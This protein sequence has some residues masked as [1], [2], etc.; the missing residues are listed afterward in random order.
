MPKDHFLSFLSFCF[1]PFQICR[2]FPYASIVLGASGNLYSPKEVQQVPTTL[3]RQDTLGC[4]SPIAGFVNGACQQLPNDIDIDAIDWPVHSL[5]SNLGTV[6]HH[7]SCHSL[8]PSNTTD[9]DPEWRSVWS[10]GVISDVV[11]VKNTS[12]HL[13]FGAHPD[14]EESTHKTPEGCALWFLNWFWIQH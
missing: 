14:I 6:E 3:H 1:I 4:C 8:P 12:H 10:A 9:P 2:F 11:S 7:V 13:S 5:D